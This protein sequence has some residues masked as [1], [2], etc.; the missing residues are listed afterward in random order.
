MQ[1]PTKETVETSPTEL[2]QARIDDTNPT[3]QHHIPQFGVGGGIHG[4]FQYITPEAGSQQTN[5]LTLTTPIE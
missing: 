4:V 3:Y 2:P 1:S 5:N